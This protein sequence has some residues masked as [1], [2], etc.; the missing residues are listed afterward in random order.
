MYKLN[1]RDFLGLST[2]GA[3]VA[4]LGVSGCS[5]ISGGPG[6][7]TLQQFAELAAQEEDSH[8]IRLRLL[9]STPNSPLVLSVN[10]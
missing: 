6:S 8:S 5:G 10:S 9:I 7:D 1:R 3:G 4:L 2:M